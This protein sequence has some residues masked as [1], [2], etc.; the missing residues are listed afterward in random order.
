MELNKIILI[1]VILLLTV[2]LLKFGK[3]IFRI[4]VIA[5]AIAAVTY[6][7]FNGLSI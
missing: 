6:I 1:A 7:Y 5:A 4:I 3:W 2:V